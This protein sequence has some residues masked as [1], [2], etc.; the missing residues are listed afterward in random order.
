MVAED[1]L[2]WK[3]HVLELSPPCLKFLSPKLLLL[4]LTLWMV[5]VNVNTG[6]T[7]DA[8]CCPLYQTLVRTPHSM[9][10]RWC[11]IPVFISIGWKPFCL[12]GGARQFGSLHD[13]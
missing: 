1:G 12:T 13:P 4:E 11:A 7:F 5:Q 6:S 3:L 2:E 9:Y 10:L 8:S